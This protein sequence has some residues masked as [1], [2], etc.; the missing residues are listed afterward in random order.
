MKNILRITIPTLVIL[1]FVLESGI[2][3]QHLYKFREGKDWR[4]LKEDSV[5]GWVPKEN[6]SYFQENVK[7][8]SG[9][10][11]NVTYNSAKYGFREWGNPQGHKKKVLVVGDS[12]TH[13]VNVS[14][15]ETYYH[16]LKEDYEVFSIAAGGYGFYQQWKLIERHIEEINPDI[17]IWQFCSNDVLDVNWDLDK[18]RYIGAITYDRPYPRPN[19]KVKWGTEYSKLFWLYKKLEFSKLVQFIG[20]KI[21]YQLTYQEYFN[22]G[23]EEQVRLKGKAVNGYDYSIKRLHDVF[24]SLIRLDRPGLKIYTFTNGPEFHFANSLKNISS[25]YGF[26]YLDGVDSS[27]RSIPKDKLIYLFAED[28]HHWNK[29]GHQLVGEMMA[30]ELQLSERASTRSDN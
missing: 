13:A 25:L 26:H 17:L 20:Q 15:N 19:G 7:D 5:V 24:G 27:L 12:F 3:I 23:I 8:L 11:S 6:F 14:N 30:Y 21:I 16:Y 1:F 22:T 2:R 29:N 4:N 9:A 28:G 18:I 10:K